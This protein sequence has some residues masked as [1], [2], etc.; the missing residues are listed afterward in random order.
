MILISHRGNISGKNK[1]RENTIEYIQEAID[2]KFLVEIDI[3]SSNNKYFFGH[4]KKSIK[5]NLDINFLLKNSKNLLI[6]CKDLESILLL[7]NFNLNYFYHNN[8]NYAI[9]SKKW[10]ISHSKN[11][12]NQLI[13]N[14]IFMLP[15][16]F[17]KDINI[18]R[19]C[20]GICSDV[21]S[22]Y[23]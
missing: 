19:K 1:K 18:F 7:Q 15:E 8:D 12:A 2:N 10:I 9:S 11:F 6:H 3:I 21:I 16:K 14:T 13:E 22:F 4:C 23:A 20:F 5:E 17:N